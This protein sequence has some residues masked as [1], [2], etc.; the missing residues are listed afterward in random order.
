MSGGGCQTEKKDGESLIRYGFLWLAV[1]RGGRCLRGAGH[2]HEF[3]QDHPG[4]RAAAVFTCWVLAGKCGA[5]SKR[6]SNCQG[7]G[8]NIL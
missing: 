8:H 3:S 7:R 4:C 6:V 1:V 5:D 2:P